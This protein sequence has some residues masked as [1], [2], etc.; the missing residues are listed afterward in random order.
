[1]RAHGV[2]DLE[3][4]PLLVLEW[5]EGVHLTRWAARLASTDRV[6]RIA[7]TLARM[8]RGL[9]HVHGRGFAHRDLKPANVL[10]ERGDR[11]RILD[12]GLAEALDGDGRPG[13]ELEPLG[14]PA[15]AAPEQLAAEA[16]P[17]PRDDLFALGVLAYELLAGRRPARPAPRWPSQLAPDVDPH[18]GRLVRR[19]LAVERD[20]RFPTAGAVEDALLG[21]LRR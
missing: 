11:P 14:T 13:A 8:C 4:E 3:G 16:R 12:F 17:D 10:V 18:L 20:A 1:M 15:Y 7:T 5:I 6:R 19:C 2:L 21:W 9:A